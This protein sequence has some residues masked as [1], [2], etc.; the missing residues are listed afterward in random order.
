MP[1]DTGGQ[2]PLEDDISHAV[3]LDDQLTAG[4]LCGG[5]ERPQRRRRKREPW[6]E[7][8][9]NDRGGPHIIGGR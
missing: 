9:E 7:Y 2:T 1:K 8:L 5:E 6:G 4:G 3:S